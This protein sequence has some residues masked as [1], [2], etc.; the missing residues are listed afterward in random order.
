MRDCVL[1]ADLFNDFEHEEGERLL[2]S[3]RQQVQGMRDLI[4]HARTHGLPVVY[5]ND[6]AGDW[7]G[8]ARTAVERARARRV[9]ALVDL[10]APAPA[11]AFLVKPRYSAFDHTPLRFVLEEL[12]AERL[13]LG[14]MATERCVAQ[15]AIDA[16]EEGF[17]VTVVRA[18][19]AAVDGELGEIALRYLRDVAGVFVVDGVADLGSTEAVVRGTR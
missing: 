3:F 15:S 16:R 14:G 19:C 11:D 13:L 17:K 2:V 7:T 18:A 10:L 8:D 6:A 9:G 12:G 4:Q 5:A 1:L